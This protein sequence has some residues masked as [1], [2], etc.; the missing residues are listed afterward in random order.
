MLSV[1]GINMVCACCW[2]QAQGKQNMTQ[3]KS[4][5]RPHSGFC[6]LPKAITDG[7]F[8]SKMTSGSK[9]HP[10][11]LSI[12]TFLSA[13]EILLTGRSLNPAIHPQNVCFHDDCCCFAGLPGN[14][15]SVFFSFFIRQQMKVKL[16]YNLTQVWQQFSLPHFLNKVEVFQN[17]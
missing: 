5:T 10:L 14:V 2:V 17:S 7:T 15:I 4:K 12:F 9:R 1:V 13:V 8:W 6:R 3:R 11:T 16:I